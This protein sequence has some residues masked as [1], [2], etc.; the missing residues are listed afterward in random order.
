MESSDARLAVVETK[1]DRL[2]GVVD[3]HEETLLAVQLAGREQSVNWKLATMLG[4]LA[5]SIFVG[6]VI[7]LAGKLLG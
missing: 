7:A 1:V 4:G 2:E 5:G 6:I 3:H